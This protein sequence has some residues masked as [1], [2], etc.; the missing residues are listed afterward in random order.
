MPQRKSKTTKM[1]NPYIEEQKQIKKQDKEIKKQDKKDFKA[2]VGRLI[3]Y[4]TIPALVII[5]M[6]STLF[7]QS[8][9]IDDKQAM[10]DEA[11]ANLSKAEKQQELLNMQITQYEDDEYIAKIL[12]KEYL[13]SKDGEIIFVMPEDALE[14]ENAST[15]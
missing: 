13:L 10:L 3:R 4:F 15:K 7:N 11:N 6:V 14:D 5:W 9:M 2:T 1:Q 12:R 8:S